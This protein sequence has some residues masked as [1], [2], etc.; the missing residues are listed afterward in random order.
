MRRYRGESRQQRQR[1]EIGHVLRPAAERLELAVARRHR[2]GD[3]HQVELAAFGGLRYLGVM[4]EIR[5]GV[6]L[7]VGGQPG[8]HVVPSWVKECSKLHRLAAA[9]LVHPKSPP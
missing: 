8:G 2:V 4:S 5:A 3:E 9:L 1:I 7:R 6:D